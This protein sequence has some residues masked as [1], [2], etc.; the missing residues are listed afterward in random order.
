MDNKP[1][2]FGRFKSLQIDIVGPLAVSRGQRYLLTIVD[3]ASRYFDALPMPTATAAQ[4]AETF[5]NGWVKTFGV[6]LQ[7][8]S[9]QGKAFISNLWRDLHRKLGVIVTYSPVYRPEAVGHIERQHKD[10]KA[11]LRSSLIQMAEEHKED[12]M[13]ALPLTLLG[14]NTTFQPD[15]EASPAE[16]VFGS[17]PALPGDVAVSYDQ[18]V[19]VPALLA[20]L[21][22]NAAK[23]PAETTI[24]SRPKPYFPPTAQNATHVYIKNPKVTP[25]SKK[26]DG[27][28]PIVQK[29]SKEIS[30]FDFLR[31]LSLNY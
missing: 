28:Y 23:K 16:L 7:A 17:N 2:Q 20:V 31:V 15:V 12:W 19:D 6:P 27:P 24:H 21:R 4:C 26:N 3:R 1:I 22:A 18:P 25:L 11:G 8:E 30:T 9:D 14:K 5:L 13:A 29:L 10:L